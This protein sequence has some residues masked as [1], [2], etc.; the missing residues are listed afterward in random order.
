LRDYWLGVFSASL[1]RS[2]VFKE[3]E[4]AAIRLKRPF[5]GKDSQFFGGYAKD[6]QEYSAFKPCGSEGERKFWPEVS[7]LDFSVFTVLLS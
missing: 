7:Q 5:I 4:C 1:A 3:P 2:G 6:G